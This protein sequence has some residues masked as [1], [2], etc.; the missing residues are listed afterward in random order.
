[1]AAAST[2]SLLATIPGVQRDSAIRIIAEIGADMTQFS[3]A[4]QALKL[5]RAE[6]I[7]AEEIGVAS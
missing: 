1:M 5:L 4:K 2:V 7:I 6:G 3:S